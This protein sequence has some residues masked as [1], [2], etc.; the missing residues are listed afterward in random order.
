M[1]CYL[2]K[3]SGEFYKCFKVKNLTDSGMKLGNEARQTLLRRELTRKE[4]FSKTRKIL[5]RE[6]CLLCDGK[7]LADYKYGGLPCLNQVADYD[8]IL[9]IFK[10]KNEG[11][12][13]EEELIQR[14]EKRMKAEALK[15]LNKYY[16]YDFSINL[17]IL[18]GIVNVVLVSL[19]QLGIM[20]IYFSIVYNLTLYLLAKYFVY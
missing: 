15:Y 13:S 17:V 1:P 16:K 7:V 3:E 8:K 18:T 19:F 10:E 4:K 14:I 2:G 12:V 20:G 5:V 9:A 11:A 6:Y